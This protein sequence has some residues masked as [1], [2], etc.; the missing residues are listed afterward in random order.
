[1]SGE[2]KVSA[3]G[4]GVEVNECAINAVHTA[5]EWWAIFRIRFEPTGRITTLVVSLGGDRVHVACDGRTHA[6]EL[7]A[8][9]IERGI[10]KSA[11]KV[12]Q[13]RQASAVTR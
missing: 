9:F 5:A 3:D 4:W 8:M 7:M 13:L 1:M 12:K 10:H 11:L 6:D 2:P